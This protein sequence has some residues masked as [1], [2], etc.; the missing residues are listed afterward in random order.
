MRGFRIPMLAPTFGKHIFFLRLEH[1]EAADFS[2][3]TR[4]AAISGK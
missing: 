4:Q 3:I 2:K 1:R